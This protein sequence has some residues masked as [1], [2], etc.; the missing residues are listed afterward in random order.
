[1]NLNRPLTVRVYEIIHPKD[2]DLYF[3]ISAYLLNN[4]D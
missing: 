3:L 2:K 1:M 4:S